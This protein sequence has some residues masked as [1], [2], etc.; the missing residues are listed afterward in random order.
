MSRNWGLAL[1]FGSAVVL[2]G[3]SPGTNGDAN[4]EEVIPINRNVGEYKPLEKAESQLGILINGQWIFAGSEQTEVDQ[5]M[6]K[7]DRPTTEF[8]DLPPGFG[9]GFR[10]R[11]WE[12][13]AEGI[14]TITH[15]SRV[16]VAVRTQKGVDESQVQ[17]TVRKYSTWL[18]PEQ[19]TQNGRL[20]RYWFAEDQGRR[21]MVCAVRTHEDS[22]DLVEAIGEETA[23]DALR[24]SSLSAGNDLRSAE[25]VLRDAAAKK[26]D[27]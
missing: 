26:K 1:A 13:D 10:S 3:C 23:M 24:M 14:G 21:L 20:A 11:G 12:T 9:S 8:R 16:V 6:R 17:S 25:R 7:P 19:P 27:P 15:N 5:A 18:T 2:S 22:Y 4:G